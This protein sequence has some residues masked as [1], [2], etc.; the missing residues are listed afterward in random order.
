MDHGD[1]KR[2]FMRGLT[3]LDR[4]KLVTFFLTFFILFLFS[5]TFLAFLRH[6]MFF[7]IFFQV[8]FPVLQMWEVE[9]LHEEVGHYFLLSL[10][11]REQRFEVLF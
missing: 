5:L 11:L 1:I 4:S 8:M 9:G 6:N 7:S 3:H 2:A 10:N